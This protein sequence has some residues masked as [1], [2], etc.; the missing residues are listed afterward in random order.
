MLAIVMNRLVR[1][2]KS[3]I[4]AQ[5]AAGVGVDVEA[6][7][8]AAADGEPD[9]V[10]GLEDVGG[11]IQVELDAADLACPDRFGPGPAVA[12]AQAQDGVGEIECQA[13]RFI[14]IGFETR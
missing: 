8:V 12:V 9:G 13:V 7:K 5:G 10:A 3:V 11:W 2:P 4:Q 6:R 1:Q 14:A